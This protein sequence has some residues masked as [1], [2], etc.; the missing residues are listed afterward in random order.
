MTRIASGVFVPQTPS[1][2]LCFEGKR[3]ECWPAKPASTPQKPYKWRHCEPT[4]GGE[5]IF[6]G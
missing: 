4:Q 6:N 2:W 3:G 5:A 1:Q